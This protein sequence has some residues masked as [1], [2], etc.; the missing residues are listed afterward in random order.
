M[1]RLA[2]AQLEAGV[3][4]WFG[5]DVA[6]H[7]HRDLGIWDPKLFDYEN[8]YDVSF[9]MSKAERLH[10]HE[11]LMTH[12]ML[13]TGV[14][15][16]DDETRRWKVENSWGESNGRKGFY[17]MND[18]WFDEYVF[19]IAVPKSALSDVLQAALS[20]EPTCLPAWDPMGALARS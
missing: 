19:E 2:R 20:D 11:T 18:E 12:A 17:L 16:L 14:D 10:F 7:M 8:L 1:K 5:C 6:P 13:F 15:V 4:V 9:E 3:P